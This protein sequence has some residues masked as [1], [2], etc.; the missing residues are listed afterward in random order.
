MLD[1][2]FVIVFYSNR[3][4]GATRTR[5]RVHDSAV[6]QDVR[7]GDGRIAPPVLV[8]TVRPDWARVVAA[9]SRELAVCN[10]DLVNVAQDDRRPAVTRIAKTRTSTVVQKDRWVVR[11]RTNYANG[12]S[13]VLHVKSST[14][15]SSNVGK[16]ASKDVDLGASHVRDEYCTVNGVERV[17]LVERYILDDNGRYAHCLVEVNEAAVIAN[18][19]AEEL[20][21]ADRDRAH[22]AGQSDLSGI[23]RE[24]F[25]SCVGYLD[26]IK[27]CVANH[28]AQVQHT[29]KGTVAT[30]LHVRHGKSLASKPRCRH[31]T[32]ALSR[33]RSEAVT[34]DG[35]V[36]QHKRA[37]TG[38]LGGCPV[39]DGN[40]PIVGQRAG[41]Q[42]QRGDALQVD[43]ND[44][45]DDSDTGPH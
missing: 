31:D 26:T 37:G 11:G 12:C 9:V 29:S 38:L 36:G 14:A 3:W 6:N 19:V 4:A 25:N 34:I 1:R 24:R 39:V 43:T 33:V 20:G 35:E 7:Q 17:Q 45:I 30:H 32:A 18:L 13:D 5:R 27:H 2:D 40:A 21:V 15:A 44:V 22:E 28:V 16:G 23:V 8:V 41:R 10:G 42:L